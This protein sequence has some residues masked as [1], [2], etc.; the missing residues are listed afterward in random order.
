MK[1]SE[2]VMKQIIISKRDIIKEAMKQII[3]LY[4]KTKSKHN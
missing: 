3:I 1:T 2:I 4:R